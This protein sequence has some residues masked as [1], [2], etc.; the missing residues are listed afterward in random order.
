MRS[1]PPRP[2]S[3]LNTTPTWTTTKGDWKVSLKTK[4]KKCF[5]YGFGCIVTVS[6]KIS[7]EPVIYDGDIP[8]DVTIEITYKIKG[9]KD[10]AMTPTT[11]VDE[12]GKH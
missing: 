1:L 7:W 4:S 2:A 9:D 8:E 6:P 12:Q 10:G 5:G 3:S 11:Q